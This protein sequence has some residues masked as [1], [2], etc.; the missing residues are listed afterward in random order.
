V[1]HDGGESS[2]SRPSQLENALSTARQRRG[3]SNDSRASASSVPRRRSLT[4]AIDPAMNNTSGM[5]TA[6]AASAPSLAAAYEHFQDRKRSRSSVSTLGDADVVDI[7]SENVPFGQPLAPL[8]P[9][10]VRSRGS[11]ERERKFSSDEDA[12]S[13]TTV[14][15][16]QVDRVSLKA[17]AAHTQLQ[18]TLS[19]LEHK[20]HLFEDAAAEVSR[21]L[22]RTY[23]SVASAWCSVVLSQLAQ[24]LSAKDRLEAQLAS[25]QVDL[26][27]LNAEVSDQSRK[28]QAAED[29]RETTIQLLQQEVGSLQLPRL[30]V[31]CRPRRCGVA[32]SSG[33]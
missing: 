5:H 27:K 13:A 26:A 8:K 11:V 24:T 33:N 22:A 18:K 1:D 10:S 29:E 12:E 4:V 32:M 2:A 25:L 30:F 15:S 7:T 16:S 14:R 20:H 28:R 6:P 17:A 19:E 21:G 23:V 3:S 9:S 31:D